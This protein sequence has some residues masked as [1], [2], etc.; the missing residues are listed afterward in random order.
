MTLGGVGVAL[1]DQLTDHLDHRP[2]LGGRMRRDRRRGDTQRAH[3]IEVESLEPL[4]DHRRLDP[5]RLGRGDDLVVDVGDVARVDHVAVGELMLEQPPQRVE[6]HRRPGVADVRAAINRRPAHIHR[7][8]ARLARH[9]LALLACHRVV[10]SDHIVTPGWRR[11]ST[12][13]TTARPLALSKG[14]VRASV[15]HLGRS[16]VPP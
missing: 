6:H 3:V 13:S 12:Q 11:V 5:L 7:H 1:G 8:P 2:D 14:K 4:G 16:A 9:E 15:I 10:Q